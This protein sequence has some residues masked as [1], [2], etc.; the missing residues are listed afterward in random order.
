MTSLLRHRWFAPFRLHFIIKSVKFEWDERKNEMN[1]QKHGVVF[2]DAVLAFDDP[3]CLIY[4]ERVEAEEARWHA[5]GA[6]NGSY[7][8]LTVVHTYRERGAEQ[9]VRII[10]A[11]RATTQE[12]KLYA[13]AIF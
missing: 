9:I 1:A 12:R 3:R 7:L 5:I 11:R 13:E 8:F 10:S 4:P 6:V 2:D